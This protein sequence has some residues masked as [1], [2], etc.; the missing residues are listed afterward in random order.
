MSK[1]ENPT[2]KTVLEYLV[3]INEQ[4]YSGIGRELGITPQQFSDWIKKRRPVPQERL[5]ALADYFQVD[6]AVLVD[7]HFFTKPLTPLARIEL[8]I[9]LVDQQV[10]RLESEKADE[11]D[12]A[13]YRE[14][15]H[16]LLQERGNQLRL[17][18]IAEILQQGDEGTA[19]LFDVVLEELDAGHRDE[20]L[21]LL[22][23]GKTL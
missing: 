9:L 7:H 18:R 14:K 3:M 5:R 19:A 20:L 10:S 12:I 21:Q 6:A 4:S 22:R 13:P 23:R 15:K 11:E 8:H 17:G 16:K 1:Q 2:S